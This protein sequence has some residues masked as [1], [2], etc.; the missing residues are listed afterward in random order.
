MDF[1]KRVA[2]PDLYAGYTLV[3]LL[4]KRGIQIVGKVSRGTA[5]ALRRRSFGYALFAAAGVLVRDINKRS[6]NFTAEQVLK[7]AS[8]PIAR[9]EIRIVA[10]GLQAVSRYLETL[11]IMPGKYQMV[12]GSG[13][14]DSNRF[15]RSRL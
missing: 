4:S 3:D 11:G 15:P 1:H 13:L 5:I 10:K 9:A 2:H 14:F 7:S 8:V 12:N 6:N